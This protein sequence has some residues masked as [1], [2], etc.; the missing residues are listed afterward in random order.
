MTDSE[1]F[2]LSRI[3]AE[4]WNAARKLAPSIRDALDPKKMAELNP[5][6]AEDDRSRWTKG[7]AKA[8]GD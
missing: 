2:R 6:A 1:A 5:Y 3:Y 4:G 8:L 7:F